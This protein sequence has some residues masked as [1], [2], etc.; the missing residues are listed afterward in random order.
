MVL[1]STTLFSAAE[2]LL[3]VP[4]YGELKYSV[5]FWRICSLVSLFDCFNLYYMLLMYL[6][7]AF[8]L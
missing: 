2:T 3:G 7:F 8:K 5:S 6:S 4:S 1:L